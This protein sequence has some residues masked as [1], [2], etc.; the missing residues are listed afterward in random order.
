M[1]IRVPKGTFPIPDDVLI[2]VA[3][4]A[5]EQTGR[6]FDSL[7]KSELAY[8]CNMLPL[9]YQGIALDAFQRRISMLRRN[10]KLTAYAKGHGPSKGSRGKKAE[11]LSQ[12]RM[13]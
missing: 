10:G 3:A 7:S 4:K 11:K 2:P 12:G 13:F 9:Q 8:Y 6:C 5:M 1:K